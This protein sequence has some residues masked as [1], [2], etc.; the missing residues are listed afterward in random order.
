MARQATAKKVER[1]FMVL[2]LGEPKAKMVRLTVDGIRRGLLTLTEAKQA[3]ELSQTKAWVADH[4][5]Y[6]LVPLTPAKPGAGKKGGRK[7]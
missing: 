2:S 6:E 4:R 7:A 5:I 1:M 3:M